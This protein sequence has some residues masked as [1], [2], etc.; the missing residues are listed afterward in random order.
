MLIVELM[1]H[2]ND[3]E[4][5]RDLNLTNLKVSLDVQCLVTP[6]H[7]YYESD[8]E[9]DYDTFNKTISLEEL[10]FPINNDSITTM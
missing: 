2:Y 6:Y 7:D 4:S 10:N 1:N 5:T 3:N 9:D 8:E